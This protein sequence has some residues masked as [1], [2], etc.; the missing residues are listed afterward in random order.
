MTNYSVL[1]LIGF[2]S[3]YE[4]ENITKVGYF[5]CERISKQEAEPKVNAE[6]KRIKKKVITET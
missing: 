6:E 2:I 4:S 5:K 1:V 3:K